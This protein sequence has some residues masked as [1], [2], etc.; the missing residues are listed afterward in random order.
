M[1]FSNYF[2][3]VLD[4]NKFNFLD[5]IFFVEETETDAKPHGPTTGL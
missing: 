1:R 2:Y 3:G 4:N 5:F